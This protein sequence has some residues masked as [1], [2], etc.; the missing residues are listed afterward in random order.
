MQDSITLTITDDSGFVAIVDASAYQSFVA[1]DWELS[2]LFDHFVGEMNKGHLIMWATGAECDWTINFVKQ[3]AAMASFREFYSTIE[4]TAGKL[5]L[6]N[7]EDL[8]MAAQYADEKIPSKH[9]AGRCIALDNGRYLLRIRQLFDPN[10][11]SYEPEGLVQ[12]EIVIEAETTA[13]MQEV[14]QIFWWTG[15]RDGG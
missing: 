15:Q 3:A 14:D 1:E 11:D 8:T 10:D 12:F 4:V 6:T 7:Y 2:Q 9:N 5:F 13:K